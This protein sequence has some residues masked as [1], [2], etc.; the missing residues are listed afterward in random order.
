MESPF[1]TSGLIK[2]T[3]FI[4]QELNPIYDGIAPCSDS[5]GGQTDTETDNYEIDFESL[6]FLGVLG[7]GAF[8]K[9]MKAELHKPLNDKG[10]KEEDY[11]AVKMLRG[12]N[13]IY[14]Y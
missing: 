1:V 8:G 9:V 12:N 13:L 4:Q 2:D 6:T 10:M 14:S 3:I 11:V 5:Y 7:E